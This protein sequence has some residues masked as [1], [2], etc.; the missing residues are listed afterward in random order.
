MKTSK[1]WQD[2]VNAAVGVSLVAS[3]WAVGYAGDTIA[4]ANSV[5]TGL[6]LIAAALSA[7]LSPHV[8]EEWTEAAVGLWAIASPWALGFSARSEATGA[9]I[10]A[11]LSV[12]VLTMWTLTTDKDYNAWLRNRTA[13]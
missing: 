8:W 9:A 13:H 2:S 3:P 10:V 5:V 11:G 4:T 7:M 6:A 1:H 12:L